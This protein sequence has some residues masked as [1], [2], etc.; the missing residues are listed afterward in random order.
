MQA[1]HSTD[2]SA[3]LDGYYAKQNISGA[4]YGQGKEMRAT[5]MTK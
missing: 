1:L 4:I 2:A 5:M 3:I